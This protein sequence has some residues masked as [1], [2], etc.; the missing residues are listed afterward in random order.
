MKN[1]ELFDLTLL[2]LDAATVSAQSLET[3]G[4]AVLRA[5]GDLVLLPEMFATGFRPDA[6]AVAQPADGAIVTALRAWAA[7]S[8]K[9]VAGS[10]AVRDGATLRNR[11]YFARPS[12]ELAWYDKRHLFRPGGETERFTPGTER[13]VVEY[14]GL[15]FLLLVCYDLRFPVWSRCRR[16]YDVILCSAAWPESRR[17]VWRTLLCARALENQA[18]IVG[19]NFCGEDPSGRYAG[20]SAIIDCY[21]RFRA[22]APERGAACRTVHFSLD[23]QNRFRERFPTWREAD[24]FVLKQ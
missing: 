1:D 21:G 16:D 10:V 6:T 5:P 14:R 13:T 24:A 17:D 23:E 12:G 7:E 19:T 15:R 4:E 2:Q 11:L 3:I 22:E 8:G 18:W 20:S 9:A